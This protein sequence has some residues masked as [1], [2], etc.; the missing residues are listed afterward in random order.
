MIEFR[1]AE[2]NHEEWKPVL[3]R[4]ELLEVLLGFVDCLNLVAT[5][6][7]ANK[8]IEWLLLNVQEVYDKLHGFK[9]GHVM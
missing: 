7:K 4:K 9:S 2:V 1:S 5:L 8:A 6:R 3:Q